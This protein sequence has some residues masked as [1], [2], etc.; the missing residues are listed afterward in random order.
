M[1]YGSSFHLRSALRARQ[2]SPSD[3]ASPLELRNRGRR[4][5][6]D[7][8]TRPPE[9]RGTP[10]IG[11]PKP[12]RA[13]LLW[14]DSRAVT[15]DPAHSARL[16]AARRHLWRPGGPAT[17][18]QM[19]CGGSRGGTAAAPWWRRSPRSRT[20]SRATPRRHPVCSSYT[21]PPMDRPG[22]IAAGSTTES[23]PCGRRGGRD[24]CAPMAGRVR[25]R[26][27]RAGRCAGRRGP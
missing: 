15:L 9:G 22:R 5:A 14:A 16:W 2:R 21:L 1:L 3:A 24:R 19:R 13:A 4:V 12:D 10:G 23:R 20:G 17:S 11:P 6:Q 26:S 18:G 25:P 7:R 27:R 8:R